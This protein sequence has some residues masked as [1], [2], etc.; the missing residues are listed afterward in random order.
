[1][2]IWIVVV[3]S[4]QGVL[5]HSAEANSKSQIAS[6][7]V[8]C[9]AWTECCGTLY[10]V[11]MPASAALYAES[12]FIRAARIA[13]FCKSVFFVK[14]PAPFFNVAAHI[15]KSQCVRF[16]LTYLMC[17]N[18]AVFTIPRYFVYAVASGI[19]VRFVQCSSACGKLPFCFRRKAKTVQRKVTG[20]VFP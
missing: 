3:V 9:G 7:S 1:M 6:F 12:S 11:V 5:L 20:Y 13:Q 16:F 19:F 15:V 2:R 8:R 10:V 17:G 18:V 14:I 4:V